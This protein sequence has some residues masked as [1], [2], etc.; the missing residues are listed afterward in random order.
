MAKKEI[1]SSPE[2]TAI[3]EETQRVIA[4]HLPTIYAAIYYNG[5]VVAPGTN[6]E[7]DKINRKFIPKYLPVNAEQV[8]SHIRDFFAKADSMVDLYGAQLKI[9]QAAVD[10]FKVLFRQ[11]YTV[12]P[13]DLHIAAVEDGYAA[14]MKIAGSD[15]QIGYFTG[16]HRSGRLLTLGANPSAEDESK[17]DLA[18]VKAVLLIDDVAHSGW[19]MAGMIAR[20]EKKYPG[21]PIIVSLAAVT[22]RAELC[23]GH[24]CGSQTYRLMYQRRVLSLSELIDQIKSYKLQQ[25]LLTLAREFFAQQGILHQEGL[26]ATHIITAYK[27]PDGTSNGTLGKLEFPGLSARFAMDTLDERDSLY[28]SSL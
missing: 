10:R 9:S 28:P 21:T 5:R 18:K 16:Y 26:S 17:F 24:E 19:Q 8:E 22:S 25:E 12:V 20:A 6:L 1:F 27:M 23:L 11:L 7:I 14:A 13:T 2:I 15:E 3:E 4:D